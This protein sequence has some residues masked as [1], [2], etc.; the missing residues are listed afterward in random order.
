M[1]KTTLIIY[2]AVLALAASSCKKGFLDSSSPSEFTSDVVYNSTTYASYALTGIYSLLT[3]DQMY[4]ARLS[5]NYATNSDIEIVGADAGSYKENTNRGLSN[6]LATPDNNSIAREWSLIYK[7]I[8]RSNL[9]IDGVKK[10]PL[11]STKDSTLMKGYMGE[12]LTLSL[13]W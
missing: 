4:S 1:K 5:L 11:M 9:F 12:A 8:E 2:I 13:N 3:Q 10:S 7:M 6:Y